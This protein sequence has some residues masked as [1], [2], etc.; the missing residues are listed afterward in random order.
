MVRDWINQIIW[1]SWMAMFGLWFVTGINLKQTAQSRSEGVSR[2][3][4]WIVWIGWWLL[5]SRGFGKEPL[6]WRVVPA[7]SV[8]AY[9]GLMLTIVGLAFA[10]WAHL[11]I[12]RNWSPLIQVKRDHELMRT[13]AY[14]IVRHP[15]YAGLMIATLGTAIA[16]GHL[17]GF[18]GFLLVVAAWGYKAVLEES[19]MLEQ[20]GAKY[21][22]Y[23]RNVRRL[24]PFVW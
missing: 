3:A 18:I 13:G 5:F 9:A 23:C 19:A 2:M 8:A 11:C 22:E 7:T 6:A 20:F 4:V 21:E 10:V 14:R 24:I 12:G 16:Y 15:I 1:M 17:S